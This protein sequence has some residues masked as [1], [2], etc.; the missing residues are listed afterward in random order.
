MA[1]NSLAPASGQVPKSAVPDAALDRV[2]SIGA[3]AEPPDDSRS[4][5]SRFPLGFTTTPAGL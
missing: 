3:M 4:F 5:S 1:V 2:R